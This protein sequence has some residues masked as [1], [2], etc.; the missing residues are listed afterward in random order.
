MW[1]SS[2]IVDFLWFCWFILVINILLS[3]QDCWQCALSAVKTCRII[4]LN[5]DHRVMVFRQCVEP[6]SCVSEHSWNDAKT[7]NIHIIVS[8]L[9]HVHC[10][11]RVCGLVSHVCG[12]FFEC[13]VSF[14]ECTVPNVLS[15]N[16]SF[17]LYY[18]WLTAF[19]R[20]PIRQEGEHSEVRRLLF[21]V[22]CLYCWLICIESAADLEQRADSLA[23]A[24]CCKKHCFRKNI[25]WSHALAVTNC[26][27]NEINGMNSDEKKSYMRWFDGCC[28][29]SVMYC[30]AQRF[31]L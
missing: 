30:N 24:Y 22:L 3:L 25:S 20:A 11:H 12:C 19:K 21:L 16:P 5:N 14:H 23:S 26:A 18:Y 28:V 2:V 13:G 7:T 27:L 31:F 15:V 17:M 1:L 6:F 10:H 4:L 9:C 29:L 8:L